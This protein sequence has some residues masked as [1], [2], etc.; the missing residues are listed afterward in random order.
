MRLLSDECSEGTP[1]LHNGECIEEELG[2][3]CNCSGTGFQGDFC[4]ESEYTEMNR[5]T[6]NK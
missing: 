1:C 2:F 3:N 6:Y 4:E 5:W